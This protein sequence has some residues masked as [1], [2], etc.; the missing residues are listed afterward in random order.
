M[1][2]VLLGYMGSGKSMLGREL[3]GRLGLPF[4]DLD[5]HIE[6]AVGMSIPEIFEQVRMWERIQSRQKK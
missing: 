2:I 4:T 3:A 6:T 5:D 1:L